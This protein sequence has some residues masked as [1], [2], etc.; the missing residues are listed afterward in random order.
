VRERREATKKK[1]NLFIIISLYTFQSW[2][3]KK[4]GKKGFS[5]FFVCNLLFFCANERPINQNF[6]RKKYVSFGNF[7]EVVERNCSAAGWF[8]FAWPAVK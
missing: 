2:R 4:V 1:I 6:L 8:F 3:K 5:S 7:G